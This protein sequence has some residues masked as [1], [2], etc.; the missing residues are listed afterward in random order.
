MAKR[1]THKKYNLSDEEPVLSEKNPEG[2]IVELLN[3]YNY[4]KTKDD[5]KSYF[6]AY[7]QTCDETSNLTKISSLDNISINN[8]IGWLCRIFMSNP[9][10]FPQKYVK[11]IEDAKDKVLQV[12]VT[13][14]NDDASV[15]PTKS[16]PSVQENIA[17]QLKTYIGDLDSILDDFVSSKCTTKFS[18][19]DWLKSKNVKHHQAAGIAD[20]FEANLL[21]EL[22]EAKDGSCEQLKEAYSFLTSNQLDA[23]ITFVQSFVADADRWE[24]ESKQLSITSRA[25]RAKK[26]KQPAKLVEKLNFLQED[27]VIKSIAPT[28]IIGAAHLLVYNTKTRALG[29]YVCTN[30]HGLSVKGST[31]VNFDETQSVSKTLRKPDVVIPQVLS[32]GRT[33]IKKVFTNIKAKEKQLTGRIN[34]DT[35]LLKVL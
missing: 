23:Y 28:Q 16:K 32:A 17:N 31:L 29:W 20:H 5:A 15:Q 18:L 13:E 14:K 22:L 2:Q 7:L 27:G 30:P 34:K 1:P 35:I 4:N 10:N 33:N 12:V 8:N 21:K 11:N 24:N 26:Q 6:L 3:W 19:Y 9:A 25:P